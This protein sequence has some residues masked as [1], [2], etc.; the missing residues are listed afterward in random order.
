[1]QYPLVLKY[2]YINI[3]IYMYIYIYIYLIYIIARAHLNIVPSLRL[4]HHIMLYI[5]SEDINEC[6]ADSPCEANAV[7]YNTESSYSCQCGE[8][9]SGDGSNCEGIYIPCPQVKTKQVTIN[10]TI[11][12]GVVYI[13]W[14]HGTTFNG[15]QLIHSFFR[16]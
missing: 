13:I 4:Y 7:C 9:Y 5:F 14:P 3:H 2:I 12:I 8:G 1:M 11:K 16:Y 15:T 6:V 10:F